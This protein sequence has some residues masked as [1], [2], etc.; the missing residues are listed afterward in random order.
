[1]RK[2]NK[3]SI[4][5]LYRQ[6]AAG[7]DASARR[8][9]AM[10]QYT[11]DKLALRPGDCV[12]DVACGTGLSFGLIESAIGAQGHLI[13]VELSPDMIT[14]ARNKVE[15]AGWENVTLIESDMQSVEL[16][17]RL[18]AILFNFTHDVLRSRT[19]LDT[20]FAAARPGARVALAGMKL[21]P[22]W[23]APLNIIVRAQAR[24]YMSSFEGLG[25]P[26]DMASGYLQSF[27]W[28]NALFTTAYIGW[29]RVK[30]SMASTPESITKSSI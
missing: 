11:I 12:L 20:I 4:V 19:A 14:L 10:R 2:T 30:Q 5:D 13:G 26:W 27:K 21:A 24:P 18:D 25:A 6:H 16:P 3:Q 23:L 17:R 8:T 9:M 1:M 7:Y 22:W 15:Q 29:G 28:E